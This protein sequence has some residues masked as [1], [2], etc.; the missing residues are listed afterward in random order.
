MRGGGTS[1]FR[2]PKAKIPP[3][4]IVVLQM[5]YRL[6]KVCTIWWLPS[7]HPIFLPVADPGFPRGVPTP[8]G[9]C[10]HSIW[11]IFPKS[12]SLAP[13]D[14]PMLTISV[15]LIQHSLDCICCLSDLIWSDL[16]W[17][18]LILSYLI[19]SYLILSYLILSHLILPVQ[20]SQWVDFGPTVV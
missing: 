16:I 9:D 2:I 4:P 10:Q 6:L 20:L 7:V 3:P 17:S 18:D 13:R 5:C 1:N 11:P 19:L 8:K 14:Q 15:T 12:M